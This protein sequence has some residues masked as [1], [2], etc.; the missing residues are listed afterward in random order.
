MKNKKAQTQLVIVLSVIASLLA[1]ATFTGYIDV[2][3]IFGYDSVYKANFGH[4][5][6]EEGAYEYPYVRYADDVPTYEC[7]AYTDECRVKLD[8]MS[9]PF[10]IYGYA[11]YEINNVDYKKSWGDESYFYL[12]Y[13]DVLKFEKCSLDIRDSSS[14]YKYSADYRRFYIQGEENGKVFVQNSCILNSDLRKRVLSD[15]LNELSKIGVNRCQNYITDYI[16]VDTKTY[17]YLGQEVLCQARN[18]YDIDKINLIDGSSRKIQGDRIKS[19]ECCPHE[20][21]CDDD[22]KFKETVTKE[23]TYDY[24]CAN[25]GLPVVLT[26]ES[27]VIFG[28]SSGI[29]KQSSPVNV[30]CTNNA[31]CVNKYNN[32]NMVCKDWNCVEDESWIGHCGDKICESVLGETPTSC[33]NDC[34]EWENPAVN[35]IF[36]FILIV[37]L[38]A[39]YYY[40]GQ[41]FGIVRTGLN[42]IGIR[43]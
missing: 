29:C 35:W 23:C 30:I 28:C 36:W 2:A 18:I 9:E 3:S 37:I 11:C 1:I 42:K 33:P 32:P 34:G 16:L 7:D 38:F 31:I 22:F 43:I 40:R 39:L 24:E 12:K 5:C 15:G 14:Y 27:Y 6:C 10:G 26:G 13:K 17:S 19:V 8:F 41:L 21:N 25:G 4:I 20:S